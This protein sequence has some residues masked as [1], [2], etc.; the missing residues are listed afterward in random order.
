MSAA[1][2]TEGSGRRRISDESLHISSFDLV[3]RDVDSI[4]LI[5]ATDAHP[6]VF[7]RGKLM[8]P[9]TMVQYGE[10]PAVAAKRALTAQVTGA[11]GLE[12]KFMELQSYTGSHWDIVIVYEFDARGAGEIKAKAP[13]ADAAFYKLSSLPREAMAEDHLEVIDGL[14][15][16]ASG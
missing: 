1:G 15:S 7:R 12:Q 2:S 5:K 14:N 10:K 8:L 4:L 16:S 6:L 9:A 11:D 3:R 13:Y